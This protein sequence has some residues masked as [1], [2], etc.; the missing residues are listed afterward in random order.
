MEYMMKTNLCLIIALFMLGSMALGP[1]PFAIASDEAWYED[2]ERS[3]QRYRMPSGASEKH[4]IKDAE[5]NL[6]D[7][8]DEARTVQN[9]WEN[10][11][12]MMV[13]PAE[14]N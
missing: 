5:N 3:T 10:S 1:M 14:G 13:K 2:F 8:V 11:T 6:M 12:Q 9:S 7:N 4:S